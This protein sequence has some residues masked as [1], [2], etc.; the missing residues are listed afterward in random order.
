MHLFLFMYGLKPMAL[1]LT[2]TTFEAHPSWYCAN[3][4]VLAA[5]GSYS[6]LDAPSNAFVFSWQIQRKEKV[7]SI[8]LEANKTGICSLQNIN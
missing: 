5:R 1:L 8:I 3:G 2:Y 6:L 7:R 4:C